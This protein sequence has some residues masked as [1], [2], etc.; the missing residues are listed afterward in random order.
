MMYEGAYVRVRVWRGRLAGD[1]HTRHPSLDGYCS[2]LALNFPIY[3]MRE[4]LMTPRA[5]SSPSTF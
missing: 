1:C 2:S 3:N 4:M 5:L